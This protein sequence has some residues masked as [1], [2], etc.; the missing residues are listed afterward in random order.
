MFDCSNILMDLNLRRLT[1]QIADR[2]NFIQNSVFAD[3]CKD[4]E[5]YEQH[6][7]TQNLCFLKL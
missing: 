1:M 5:Q 2:M 3:L 6:I 4:K 7:T